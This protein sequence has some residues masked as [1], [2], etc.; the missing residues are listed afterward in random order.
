MEQKDFKALKIFLNIYGVVSVL[1][2][3]SLFILTSIHAPIIQEGGAM[4]FVRWETAPMVETMLEGVYLVWGIFFFLAARKPVQYISFLS[5]TLW[6]NLFHGLI[7]LVQAIAMPMYLYKLYSDV[8][9]CFV[10]AIGLAIL[11]PRGQESQV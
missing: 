1:L 9:Y 8:S 5:F 10:L 4:H 6:A 7:M 3:G 11:K 2:F